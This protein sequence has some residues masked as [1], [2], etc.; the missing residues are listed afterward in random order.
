MNQTTQTSQS[1]D[2]PKTTTKTQNVFDFIKSIMIDAK[3]DGNVKHDFTIICGRYP[4]K[5]MYGETAKVICV[6]LVNSKTKQAIKMFRPQLKA[7]DRG[8]INLS[9]NTKRKYAL[10]SIDFTVVGN[11]DERNFET[12]IYYDH[13]FGVLSPGNTQFANLVKVKYDIHDTPEPI[14]VVEMEFEF[15]DDLDMPPEAVN[16]DPEA[17]DNAMLIDT[18]ITNSEV[19]EAATPKT[20]RGRKPS[21]KVDGKK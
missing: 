5:S 14:E 19:P 4:Y 9:Y 12:T 1:T 15:S 17:Y 20:S 21:A 6:M 7:A 8:Y 13:V 18:V 3:L 11:T 2:E 16:A 10:R